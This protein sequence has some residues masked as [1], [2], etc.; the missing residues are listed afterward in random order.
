MLEIS[1]QHL[2]LMTIQDILESNELL[3]K[4]QLSLS[5]E[6]AVE[7]VEVQNDMLQ[8]YKRI[9]FQSP[10]ITL[11]I[12]EFCDS[13]FINTYNFIDTIKEL[14]EIYYQYKD[15]L[16]DTIPDED[17]IHYLK[18]AFDECCQG[19]LSYLADEQ[20]QRL[21]DHINEGYDIY[22]GLLYGND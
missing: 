7:L 8:E 11:L 4:Y 5:K 9:E 10:I 22:E 1:F 19:S 13:C 21:I 16:D 17:I 6:E 20:L 2:N 15:A 14:I 12:E 18:I 3:Q